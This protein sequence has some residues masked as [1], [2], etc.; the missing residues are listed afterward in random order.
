MWTQDH[1][2]ACLQFMELSPHIRGT[3]MPQFLERPNATG[4]H[5]PKV[6]IMR[7]LEGHVKMLE[8]TLSDSKT[9]FLATA[10][11]A[12]RGRKRVKALLAQLSFR[13]LTG[14]FQ[15]HL[16]NWIYLTGN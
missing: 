3:L 2:L 15:N 11:F 13:T 6:T 7:I 4:N 1:I 10:A 8:A 9:K 14:Y 5:C 16:Y 12:L